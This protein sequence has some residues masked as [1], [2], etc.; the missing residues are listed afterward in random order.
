MLR[1]EL[2][3]ESN[4]F[5]YIFCVLLL[6]FSIILPLDGFSNKTNSHR[7]WYQRDKGWFFYEDPVVI[8]EPE[9][10]KKETPPVKKEEAPLGTETLRK[11]GEKLLSKAMLEPSELN[12]KNYMEHQK[13]MLDLSHKFAHMWQRVLMKYPELYVHASTEGVYEDTKKAIAELGKKAGLFFFYSTQCPH[14]VNMASVI[15]EFRRKHDFSIIPITV[16]GRV[17]PEFPDTLFDNGLSI[18]LNVQTV[19]AI[20]LAYPGEDRFEHIA[21]G[22]IHL[23][24]LERRLYYYAITETYNYFSPI[25]ISR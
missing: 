25:T 24:D 10:A 8:K 18:V 13:K 19:P 15:K 6:V 5:L 16:D 14:C 11:E 20:F 1:K 17:L 2:F 23:S 4:R 3:L 12:I 22:A 7:W 9:D 21:T